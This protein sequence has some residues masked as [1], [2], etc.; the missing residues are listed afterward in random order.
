MAYGQGDYVYELDQGWGRLPEGLK[1]YMVAGVSVDADDQVYLFN[2]SDHQMMV[3][4]RE[5]AFIR[6]WD[7]IFTNPH[8]VHVGLDGNVY[9]SDRDS[10]VVMKYSPEQQLLLTLGTRDR[11]SDTG[12]TDEEKVVQRAA[13]P[14]NLPSGIAVTEAGDIFISDGYGNSR[15]HKYDATGS[16][17]MSWGQPGTLNP[18]EFNLVHGIGLHKDGRLLVCDRDNDRIQVYDQEGEWQ[19]TWTD[20]RQPTGAVG[21]PDGEVYVSELGHRVSILD[22]SGRVLSRWGEEN[23]Y[24]PGLFAAPHAV[25][26]D[27]HGDLY[28]GEVLDGERIQKFKRQR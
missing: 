21:G 13:G 2:R 17:L 5:G 1:I 23:S 4:D 7:K 8:G 16:L 19:A 9:L 24:E 27:S 25:A 18:G 15:V 28:V 3:F 10:H 22:G 12:Y 20:L 26:I 11:P 6:S 14:F